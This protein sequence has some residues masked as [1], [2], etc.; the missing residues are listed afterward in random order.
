MNEWNIIKKKKDIFD[1]NS[2]QFNLE[3]EKR[4]KLRWVIE[5]EK[6]DLTTMTRVFFNLVKILDLNIISDIQQL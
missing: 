5:I 2:I 6:G 1:E 4:K 3:R